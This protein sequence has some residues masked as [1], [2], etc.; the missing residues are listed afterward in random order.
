M[1][2][3]RVLD[4]NLRIVRPGL[5]CRFRDIIIRK[6]NGEQIQM[7]VQG[8]TAFVESV[9]PGAI[10]LK[11]D[12]PVLKTTNGC[13][14]MEEIDQTFTFKTKYVERFKSWM[15]Q[16]NKDGVELFVELLED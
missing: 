2:K 15:A 8:D 1:S 12:R 13:M 10:R 3:V 4:K 14:E 16:A 5:R 6:R 7:V 11:A 9:A